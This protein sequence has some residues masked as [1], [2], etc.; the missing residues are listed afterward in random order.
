MIEDIR[1]SQHK[2]GPHKFRLSRFVGAFVGQVYG[3]VTLK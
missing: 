3:L 2:A 1:A